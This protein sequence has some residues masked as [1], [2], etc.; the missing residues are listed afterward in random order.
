MIIK[1]ETI[2]YYNPILEKSFKFAVRIVRFYKI[3]LSS[4]Y[5]LNPLL[6]QLLRSGTSVGANTS[7]AQSAVTKKDF[8]NKLGIS[9][10]ESRETEYWL[11]LLKETGTIS[12]KEFDS[13]FG[14]CE[15]LSKLLTSI[16]KSSKVK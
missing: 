7:E 10:K 9:L 3:K 15:E 8:I 6:K 5:N 11:K 13:L 12:D 1:E 4:D 14:D 2:K 16:I